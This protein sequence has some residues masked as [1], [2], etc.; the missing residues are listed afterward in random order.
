MNH[1]PIS[2]SV[3]NECLNKLRIENPG[4]ATIR[5]IFMLSGLIQEQSGVEFI[6]MELGVPGLPAS[7]IGINAEIEALQSGVASVYGM[8]DGIELLKRE[9]ARF[10]KLFMDIDVNQETCI[11]TVGAMQGTYSAMLTASRAEPGKDTILFIDPG[12]PVQKQQVAVMGAK[13]KSFDIKNHRGKKLQSILESYLCEGNICAILFSN[14]NNP[15]WVC[16]TDEE[17]Q[18]LADVAN[19]HNVILMEDLA[20]FAMDFRQHLGEPGKAPFQPSVA[21]YTDNWIM[22]ISSSKIF[23]YAGQRIAMMI[24]SDK[25]YHKECDTFKETFNSPTFGSTITQRVLYALSSGTSHSAQYAM[26]AMLK[27]A[28]DGKYAF[29]DDIK[30]YG[31]KAKAMKKIFIDNGFHIIYDKDGEE[32]IA[33]GFYFTVGYQDMTGKELLGELLYYG[34]S[35]ITLDNTGSKEEGLRAC[36]SFVKKEQLTILNER[37]QLFNQHFS[38]L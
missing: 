22:F 8:V 37:L 38:K 17:L 18:I 9:T 7:E 24:I 15:T 26:A 4:K 19:K 29:V 6:R 16:M 13:M 27:A 28:N 35:A 3:V 36:T 11:P 23:S 10:V 32:N 30:I 21:K 5:D 31:E 14:P 2:E 33:D 1:T 34:I 20:Y 25:I 12:F